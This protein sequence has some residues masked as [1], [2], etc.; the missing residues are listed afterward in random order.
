MTNERS[1]LDSASFHTIYSPK[2]CDVFLK[3][4]TP[5]PRG[6]PPPLP[7]FRLLFPPTGDPSGGDL[8]RVSSRDRAHRGAHGVHRLEVHPR[9]VRPS[10]PC[11]L[12]GHGD[13]PALRHDRRRDPD[14]VAAPGRR[15]HGGLLDDRDIRPHD[16]D[17]ARWADG[18]AP[19]GPA[20]GP[21]VQQTPAPA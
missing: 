18:D 16:A 8:L 20:Q 4:K 14:P 19:D 1:D 21:L 2:L 13:V 11:G 12:L 3:S 7:V 17:G 6:F 9:V 15:G 10:F 5:L